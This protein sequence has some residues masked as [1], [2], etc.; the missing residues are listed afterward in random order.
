VTA[1]SIGTALYLNHQNNR[2]NSQAYNFWLVRALYPKTAETIL[3]KLKENSNDFIAL[4]EKE[5]EKQNAIIAATT[6]ADQADKE[7]KAA[8]DNLEKVKSGK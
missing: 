2:L 5:M 3:T 8:K 7:Q 1:G 6:K 4:A